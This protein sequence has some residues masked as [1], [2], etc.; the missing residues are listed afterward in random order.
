MLLDIPEE[1]LC[2]ITQDLMI[3]PVFTYD[4][5]TYEREA[6]ENWLINQKKNTSPLTGAVLP[7]T[8]VVPNY[9]LRKAIEAFIERN[10][11]VFEQEFIQAVKE[12]QK[13]VVA[14]LLKLRVSPNKVYQDGYTA[15]HWAAWHGRVEILQLL[16]QKSANINV[17]ACHPAK[18]T[19]T[20]STSSTSNAGVFG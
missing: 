6:I 17:K 10:K 13:D 2:P 16:I 8:S 11:A 9:A 14:S 3:D 12:G 20:V 4:G 15:L 19:N 1:Y 18:G 7:N 5:Q